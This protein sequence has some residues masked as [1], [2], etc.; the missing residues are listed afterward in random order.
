MHRVSLHMKSADVKR[1]FEVLQG[2][3]ARWLSRPTVREKSATR[4]L[5]AVAQ[6][7]GARRAP[8]RDHM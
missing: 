4:S 5:P 8:K 6:D 2:H 7:R 3:L 1:A